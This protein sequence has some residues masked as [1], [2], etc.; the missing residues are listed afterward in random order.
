M[1]QEWRLGEWR[2]G[3][4]A[5]LGVPV[6]EQALGYANRSAAPLPGLTGSLRE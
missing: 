4:L 1:K 6:F 3:G 2:L 5:R